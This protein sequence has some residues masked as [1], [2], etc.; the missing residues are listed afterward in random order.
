M[1]KS[2]LILILAML[3]NATRAEGKFELPKAPA[4]FEWSRLDDARAAF[5]CPAGWHVKTETVSGTHALFISREK[6]SNEGKFE[7]G[8]TV[9]VAN[10]GD[11]R[12]AVEYAKQY[13]AQSQKGQSTSKTQVDCGGFTGWACTVTTK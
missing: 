1:A 5:L 2:L 9:N 11:K 4:G 8:L 13:I 3:P 12:D 10:V 6:I 7:T